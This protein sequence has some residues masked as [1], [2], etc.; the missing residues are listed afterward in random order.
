MLELAP[1]RM[2]GSSFQTGLLSLDALG[3]A[4]LAWGAVHEFLSSEA[5][6][7]ALS[8]AVAFARAAVAECETIVCCDATRAMYSPGL[9]ARGL[10]SRRMV[11]LRP[12]RQADEVWAIA[13]CLRCKGVSAVIAAPRRLSRVEARRLQL[14]AEHGGGV[15][16]FMRPMGQDSICYAAAT[17][18]LVEPA[19]GDQS[20]Q[21]WNVRLLHGHGRF[22][23]QSVIVEVG[24]D[25]N[26][27]RA[28]EQLADPAIR[29][30]AP[31]ALRI[32]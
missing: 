20:T 16:L 30:T 12:R 31:A 23:G 2:G 21:R 4:N 14:A 18:W 26:S 3:Q 28:V 13:E 24:R 7:N 9:I 19:P 8:I 1:C 29:K 6:G 11:I 22:V 17:R 25:D 27:V 15:G 10:D 32:A 5:D